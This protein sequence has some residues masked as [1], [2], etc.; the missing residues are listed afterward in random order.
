MSKTIVV[1]DLTHRTL[2]ELAR[3]NG[4]TIVGQLRFSLRNA[5]ENL[6]EGDTAADSD[7]GN[8]EKPMSETERRLKELSDKVRAIDDYTRVH[9]GEEP[10]EYYEMTNEIMVLQKKLQEEKGLT[11]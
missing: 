9:G 4:R 7:L 3:A 8:Q 10:E 6:T 11:R 1:D 2:K 5:K